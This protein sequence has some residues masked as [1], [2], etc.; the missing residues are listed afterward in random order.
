MT[1]FDLIDPR[2]GIYEMSTK[3]LTQIERMA[4]AYVEHCGDIPKAMR[5]VAPA[6]EDC[7][8]AQLLSHFRS[9]YQNLPAFQALVLE[10]R[11]GVKDRIALNANDLLMH[12]ARQATA[13]PA[14]IVK[15]VTVP[16]PACW[17]SWDNTKPRPVLPNLSCAAC[18]GAGAKH[19]HI[20]DTD[21]LTPQA[22]LLYRGAEMTKHGIKVHMA[23]PDAAAD[24]IAKAIGMF[25]TQLQI[26]SN[27]Q[28]LPPPEIPEDQNAA[29]LAYS[30]WVQK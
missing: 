14:E 10:F 19:V 25:T 13:D 24:K 7:T 4:R 3:K 18:A 9:T 15:I 2:V 8:D 1:P 28:K 22:R 17:N 20:T 11:E 27:L 6:M 21:K 5:V 26:S 23:D 12:W 16:C 29:S 30:Q